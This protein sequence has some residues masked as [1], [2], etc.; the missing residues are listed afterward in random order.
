MR[1]RRES[2]SFVAH[3]MILPGP[4][5]RPDDSWKD[6]YESELRSWR[7]K[8]DFEKKVSAF[9]ESR[10]WKRIRLGGIISLMA[11]LVGAIFFVYAEKKLGNREQGVFDGFK[12][13]EV[14]L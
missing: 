7:K 10:F 8:K 9:F 6:R 1:L 11:I 13:T 4:D 14:R 5:I 12:K 3:K 2:R